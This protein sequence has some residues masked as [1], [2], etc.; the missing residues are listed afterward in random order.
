MVQLCSSNPV[1]RDLGAASIVVS[2]IALREVT[3]G[4]RD[5]GYVSPIS[6]VSTAHSSAF[7]VPLLLFLLLNLSVTISVEKKDN[8]G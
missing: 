3:P 8:R 1:T 5:K 7:A 6:S 4:E 2:A